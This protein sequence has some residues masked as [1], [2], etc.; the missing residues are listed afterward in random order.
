MRRA[1]TP[2]KW[3][4]WM[5]VMVDDGPLSGTRTCVLGSCVGPTVI[6]NVGP[7]DAGWGLFGFGPEAGLGAGA[8]AEGVAGA[9]ED[10][11]VEERNQLGMAGRRGREE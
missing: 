9:G 2:W 11:E 5:G 10:W 7:P 1:R 6:L 8:E 4:E 3:A